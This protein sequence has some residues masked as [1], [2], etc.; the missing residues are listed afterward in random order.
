MLS[1]VRTSLTPTPSEQWVGEPGSVSVTEHYNAVRRKAT[2]RIIQSQW[3]NAVV[4]LQPLWV[5]RRA[6]QSD[7]ERVWNHCKVPTHR[8]R[9]TLLCD[10]QGTGQ[11]FASDVFG[12]Y[13]WS[14]RIQLGSA[15]ERTTMF[16]ALYRLHNPT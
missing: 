6:S 16:S 2:L 11:L 12:G 10:A 4:P 15:E 5:F 8:L 14:R 13:W 7:L 1:L 3:A 9:E